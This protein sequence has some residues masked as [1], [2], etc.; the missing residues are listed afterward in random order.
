MAD[1][2]LGMDVG[3]SGSKGVLARPDGSV[4]ATVELPHD[5]DFPRPGFVEHDPEKVWWGDFTKIVSELLSKADGHEVR[6]SR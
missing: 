2:L 5:T 4:I 6:A 3:T 1:A